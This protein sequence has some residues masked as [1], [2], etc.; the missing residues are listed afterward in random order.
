MKH[1]T[2]LHFKRIITTAILFAI[3]FFTNKNA[4]AQTP[5]IILGRPTDTSITASIMF[6]QVMQYYVEYGTTTG[7]YPNQTTTFTS[8]AKKPFEI[9]LQGLVANTKYFYRVQY[10]TSGGNF[11]PTPEY[12]FHTQ[13]ASGSTFTFTVEADEHLYDYGNPHLYT[14]TLQN[15]LNDNPDFMFTLGDIFGDDHYPFTITQRQVDS[16]RYLY[17]PRLGA[18]CHSV[19][20]NVCL[21]N[22]DGEKQYY[23]DTMPPNNLAVWSTLSRKVYYPNPEPN[24]FYSGNNTAE[25]FGI[26]LPQDYYAYT[27]GDALFVVL[28]AYRFDCDTNPKPNG[29]AWT[30]GLP[31]YTWLK[32]T[33]Q[34]S[35]AKFKFAF[36]HHPLGENRG[37]IIPAKEYEWGGNQ[38]TQNHY[39]FNTNRPGWAMPVQQLF[40]TYGVQILFQG[41]DH[42][43][44][45]E[46]LDSVVYQEVPM[47]ADSTYQKGMLANASAY[48]ADTIAGSG[49]IRVTVSSSCVQVDYV[50]SYLPKDT[51]SGLH[52]NGT[53]AFS[54]TIGTCTIQPNGI[55]S[56]LAN[57]SAN[58]FPNPA[59]DKLMVE[60]LDGS[61]SVYNL[62]LNDVLGKT[63]LTQ[64]TNTTANAALMDVSTIPNGIYFLN[65]E[66]EHQGTVVKKVVINH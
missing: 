65:I 32:N 33:L 7:S 27:W 46:I 23:L 14:I 49:Y 8:V 53:V 64:N 62:K 47:A 3:L 59:N 28:D 9:D 15:E 52:H 30:L 57:S 29:W 12:T 31:Q 51:L 66:T 63:V 25:G 61:V 6:G 43:F 45:H 2:P 5:N 26:G 44:A 1:S 36:I 58:I 16:L 19:P 41:H 13:R 50:Q 10:K 60:I 56:L 42:L 35:T 21:G 40:R 48:T 38:G 37:G 34:N 24:G 4:N 18:I 11:T 20:L 54:Y 39:T 17:R 22:H 55:K